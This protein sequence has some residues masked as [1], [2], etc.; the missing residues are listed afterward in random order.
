MASRTVRLDEEAEAA[1]RQVQKATGLPI[2]EALKRGLHSLS[3]QIA[4][5]AAQ[6]PYEIYRKLD[7]G[8]GGYAIAPSTDTRR[9]V[10]QALRKK[11]HR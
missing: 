9:G 1:L 3:S 2:S 6:T 11:L 4:Q 5:D 8:K 7:L 10:T